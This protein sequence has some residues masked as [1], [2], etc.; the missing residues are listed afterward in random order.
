MSTGDVVTAAQALLLSAHSHTTSEDTNNINSVL[1]NNDGNAPSTNLLSNRAFND[2]YDC[3]GLR[4]EELFR[5]G[6]NYA[7]LIQSA[8]VKKVTA[9]LEN[10]DAIF[11]VRKMYF[12]YVY[13]IGHSTD[14]SNL[15]D[16]N[17]AEE[18][19]PQTLFAHPKCLTTIGKLIMN[20]KVIVIES[21]YQAYFD[22]VLFVHI[23]ACLCTSLCQRRIYF[24]LLLMIFSAHR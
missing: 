20:I 21:I 11:P 16:Q 22:C 17:Y 4:S 2:A 10:Q 8:I 18:V 1:T 3:L 15:A 14:G 9:I 12:T 7:K 6:V 13:R 23:C 5:K 19:D 24:F